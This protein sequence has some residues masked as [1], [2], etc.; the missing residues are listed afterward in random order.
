MEDHLDIYLYPIYITK[1]TTITQLITPI[2]III[3][4]SETFMHALISY[5]SS[6]YSF[7]THQII[8]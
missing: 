2:I 6:F 3:S 8:S 7:T 1:L 5:L 4:H